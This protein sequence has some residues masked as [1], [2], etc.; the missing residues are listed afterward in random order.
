MVHTTTQQL[1]RTLYELTEANVLAW[2]K[3]QPT[4]SR[5]ETEGYVV[6]VEAQPPAL[7]L[8]KDDGLLLES[9][10][11]EALAAI[12]WPAG[13]GTFATRV[14]EMA[15]RAARVWR[16]T[17]ARQDTM[18]YALRALGESDPAQAR[19]ASAMAAVQAQFDAN[20]ARYAWEARRV[21]RGPAR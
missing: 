17:T 11:A 13:E 2:T 14:A 12:P 8:L 3:A 7:R 19:K 1:I 18:L 20:A 4:G 5:L 10:S 6:E 21:Q 16:Q 15:V 9:A